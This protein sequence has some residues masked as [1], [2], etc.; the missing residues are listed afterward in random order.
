MAGLKE[1][2]I[3]LY[4]SE[5]KGLKI[6]SRKFYDNS[7]SVKRPKI[8]CCEIMDKSGITAQ[9]STKMFKNGNR[10]EVYRVCGDVIKII[11]NKFGEIQNFS[12]NVKQKVLSPEHLL[13]NIQDAFGTKINNIIR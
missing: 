7:L 2:S 3:P 1:V 5:Q 6:L 10:F 13:R 11:K 12:T 8:E 9:F 4:N